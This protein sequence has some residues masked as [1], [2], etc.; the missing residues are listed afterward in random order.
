MREGKSY[1]TCDKF[2]LLSAIVAQQC[3][4][5]RMRKHRSSHTCRRSVGRGYQLP[6]NVT[7]FSDF[8]RRL[9]SRLPT[10]GLA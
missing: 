2:L 9:M 1:S 6:N 5:C 4:T 3:L 10:K 7:V 8:V